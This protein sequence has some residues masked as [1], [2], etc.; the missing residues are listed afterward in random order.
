MTPSPDVRPD[1]TE[2]LS[3]ALRDRIMVLDGAMGTM[4]QRYRLEE[5]DYRGERFA[6]WPSD[7]KGNNDLLSLTC[8]DAIR[9]IHRAYLEAGADIIETNTFSATTIA[10]AE[11]DLGDEAVVRDLNTR[12][13]QFPGNILAGAFGIREQEFFEAA[14][15]ERAVP[16]DEREKFGPMR[17]QRLEADIIRHARHE[18]LVAAGEAEGNVTRRRNHRHQLRALS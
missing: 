18:Q 2:Q 5:A 16:R 17:V 6:D 10:Q 14:E 12:I 11:Y 9:D 4:I 15:S 13:Q 7:L 1:A 8:P 3:A